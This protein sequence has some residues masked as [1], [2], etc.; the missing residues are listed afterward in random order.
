MIW[1]H[2]SSTAMRFDCCYVSNCS[3]AAFVM[4][5]LNESGTI[6]ENTT[7]NWLNVWTVCNTQVQLSSC[8]L[9]QVLQNF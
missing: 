8:G 7:I 1:R 3:L 5:G 2:E 9:A 4:L 6:L